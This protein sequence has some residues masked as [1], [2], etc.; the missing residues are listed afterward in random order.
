MESCVSVRRKEV[1]YE[2][3]IYLIIYIYIFLY[4]RAMSSPEK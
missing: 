2:R 4:E 3:N 1:K